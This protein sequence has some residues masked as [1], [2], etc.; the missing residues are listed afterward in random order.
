MN[1]VALLRKLRDESFVFWQSSSAENVKRLFVVASGYESRSR[2]LAEKVL[3]SSHSANATFLVYGF[4]EYKEMGSRQENDMFYGKNK[5]D[6]IPCSANDA[7][8]FLGSLDKAVTSIANTPNIQLEVHIDYSCMPRKW[9]CNIPLL[10]S[11]VLRANHRAYMWYTP[12]VYPKPEYPTAGIHDFTVSSGHPSLSPSF[13]THLFGLGFDKVRSAAI[14]S[15]LDPEHLICFYA[16]PAVNPQYATRV[17]EDNED[18]LAAAS[19]ILTVPLHEFV[20]AYSMLGSLVREYRAKGDVI[21]V[22]DGPKPL[23]LAASL[24]PQTHGGDGVVCFH[25]TRGKT[26]VFMPID[27]LPLGDAFG[28]SFCGAGTD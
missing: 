23:I 26:P 13:R 4:T 24:I 3:V 17:R 20:T 27:V 16:D 25:V 2:A 21:L 1:K 12:G 5:L 7:D 28:F 22:P 15:V 19:H 10:L 6:V 18:V 14:H 9:Y 8:S 11:R